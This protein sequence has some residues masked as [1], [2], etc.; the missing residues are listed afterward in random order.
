MGFAGTHKTKKRVSFIFFIPGLFFIL[1]GRALSSSS[2]R[3]LALN[4]TDFS[5][6]EATGRTSSPGSMIGVCLCCVCA[7]LVS[8]FQSVTGAIL[9]AVAA[10]LG[11]IRR[12]VVFSPFRFFMVSIVSAPLGTTG[13]VFRLLDGSG[14]NA[15]CFNTTW[16]A[17]SS[18]FLLEEL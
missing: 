7:L 17:A 15:S 10:L 8:S 6:P 9:V 3:L 11:N 1:L 2:D 4:D 5:E 12:F 14:G 16:T 13:A 18:V